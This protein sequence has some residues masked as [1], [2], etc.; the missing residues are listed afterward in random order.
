MISNHGDLTP[1]QI[2]NIPNR[3]ERRRLAKKRGIFKHSGGWR[4]VNDM[5]YGQR[6]QAIHKAINI[7]VK[8]QNMQRKDGEHHLD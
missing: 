4:K 6:N 8:K 3:G 5:A 2:P 7:Q 1:P